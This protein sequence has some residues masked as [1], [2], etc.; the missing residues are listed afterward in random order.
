MAETV[1]FNKVGAILSI[2]LNLNRGDGDLS[3]KTIIITITI[4]QDTYI[5]NIYTRLK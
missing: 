4:A 5:Y 1:D 3:R 2:R